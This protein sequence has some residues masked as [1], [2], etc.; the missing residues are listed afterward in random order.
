[1][2][3]SSKSGLIAIG[4]AGAMAVVTPSFAAPV[5]SNAAAGLKAA[6]P[7]DVVD[8]QWRRWHHGGRGG[9]IAGLAAGA[10]LGAGIAAATA[11]RYSYGPGYAYPAYGAYAYDYPYSNAPLTY[12]APVYGGYHAY[13]YQTCA[14]DAGYGRADYSQC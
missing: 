4:L 10:L 2:I 7:N 6:V 8:V 13:P 12:G 11:P 9:A 3:I 1:M 5:L 14:V